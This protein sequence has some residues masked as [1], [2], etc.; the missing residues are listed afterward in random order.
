[1]ATNPNRLSFELDPNLDNSLITAHAGVPLVIEMFRVSGA[2]AKTN[3]LLRHKKK[4]LGLAPAE[5]VESVLA[6]WTTGGDRLEDFESFRTDRALVALL[7]HDLPSP[8]TARDFFNTFHAGKTDELPPILWSGD[9]SVVYE[10]APRL[11]ALAEVNKTLIDHVQSRSIETDATVDLDAVILECDRK[12]AAWT[13]EGTKGYQPVVA[14]WVEQD[15]ILCDEYR[16][17][18]VPARSGNLRV[19]K[20]AMAQ[21]PSWVTRKF[22]RGDSACYEEAVLRH[23]EREEDRVEYAISAVMSPSLRQ[24]I[25]RLPETAWKTEK[26]VGDSLRQWAEV[27]YVGDAGG[28]ASKSDECPKRRYLAIRIIKQQ[29]QLFEDGTDRKHFAVV[30]NRPGDGLEI[31]Q[32]HREKAGTIEHVHDVV[33]NGLAGGVIPSKRFGAKAAWF[34][35]NT[36]LYNLL[37]AMRKLALPK[38]F[39][40][41]KPKRL[42]FK[43]FNTVGRVV[44]HAREFLLRLTEDAI[45]AVYDRTRIR[46]HCFKPAT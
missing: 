27:T 14:V 12:E 39:A 17:G 15:Q 20:K 10:E 29:G 21:L 19:I 16:D 40:K 2:A 41:A 25:M 26:E 3:Q 43:L 23:L 35:A 24:E 42:R 4:A 7:E 36:I 34:R 13:Y 44:R 32:W 31:L 28:Y 45:Q 11:Q 9:S 30:T 37:S 22:F 8:Q 18:N 38:E 1:M 33:G 5:M 6:L 46:I